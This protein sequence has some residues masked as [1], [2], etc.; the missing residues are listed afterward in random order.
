[1]TGKH[2]F[3]L[4][5]LVVLTTGLATCGQL[6]SQTTTGSLK[7]TITDESGALVPGVTVTATRTGG[8]PKTGISGADGAYILRGLTPGTY[9]VVAEIPGLQQLNLPLY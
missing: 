3:A 8:Q 1:M 4:C 7:G 6:F 5:S 2:R 9:T